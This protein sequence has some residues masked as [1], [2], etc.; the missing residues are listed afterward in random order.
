MERRTSFETVIFRHPFSLAGFE[1]E[2]APGV[3]SIEIEEEALDSLSVAGWRHI[4]TIIT[5]RHEGA[6]EYVPIDPLEL[7]L[8]LERDKDPDWPGLS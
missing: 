3:Y 5:L 8:A 6:T 1:R 4:A 2:A 7:R